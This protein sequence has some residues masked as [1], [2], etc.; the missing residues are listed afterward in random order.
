[1][2]DLEGWQQQAGEL[3]LLHGRAAK[4]LAQKSQALA[5]LGMKHEAL[6]QRLTQDGDR[7]VRSS[8]GRAGAN[9]S[10]DNRYLKEV[11]S[12]ELRAAQAEASNERATDELSSLSKRHARMSAEHMTL[13]SAM[14]KSQTALVELENEKV[15]WEREQATLQAHI[16]ELSACSNDRLDTMKDIDRVGEGMHVVLSLEVERWKEDYFALY[17]EKSR[18]E[19]ALLDYKVA[20]TRGEI[21]LQVTVDLSCLA[22]LAYVSC[23]ASLACPPCLTYRI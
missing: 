1:L 17:D 16:K 11:R 10:T 9:E 21:R 7:I 18:W 12:A 20:V 14:N 8:D 13:A 5:M 6:E 4:N 22:C 19:G 2:A 15:K 3:Q 23:P